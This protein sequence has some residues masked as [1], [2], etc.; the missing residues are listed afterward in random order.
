MFKTS[1]LDI[2]T[3]SVVFQGLVSSVTLPGEEG[4]LSLLDFHEPIIICLK[5]GAVKIDANSP[6]P[7]KS[8]IASMKNNELIM[9]LEKK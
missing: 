2:K 3:A 9:L 4:E 8:G 5:E 1:V 6:M 7:I